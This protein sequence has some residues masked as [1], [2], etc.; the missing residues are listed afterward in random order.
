[1]SQL[2]QVFYVSRVSPGVDERAIRNILSLSRRTNRMLDVTGCL[3]FT[4]EH[5]AQV[6]EGREE[7]IDELLPRIAADPRHADFRLVLER[8]ITLR[9]YPLWSMAYL[10][11]A[12]LS[13]EIEGLYQASE[14]SSRKTLQLLGRLKP[15]TVVGAL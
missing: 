3:S 15:D 1:M 2:K 9:E 6:L 7:S 10:P 11:S 4:G 13:Q 5:F 14:P 8:P 12:A